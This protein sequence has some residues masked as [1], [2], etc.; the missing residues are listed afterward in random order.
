MVWIVR[1]LW[2]IPVLPAFAAAL[3]SLA[4]Q[5]RRKFAAYLAIGSMSC[6]LL[7]SLL[8]FAH[9]LHHPS[10]EFVNFPWLQFGAT[11]LAFGWLLN[12]LTAVMLVMVSFVGLLIFVYSVGYMAHDEN[13]TRFFCFLSLFAGAMLGIVIS[14]NLLLLFMNWEI[15]G[16]T[17]YLLIGFWYQRPA[18]AAAAKK[19]FIVTRIGDL[20]LF[21]GMMWLYSASG[22]LLFY[23]NGAGCLEHSAIAAMASHGVALGL[24]ASSAIALL[25]FCGAAGK[26]GQ[27]PLHV[28]LPDAMEG[29]TPVSALIHAAT[30]VAAGVFLVARVYPLV[31]A[32]TGT[33]PSA[34]LEVI[35]W[36]GAITALFAACIAVAQNDIKRILA[37]STVSQLGYMMLGLAVG[38]VAVGMFHLI[39]HAFFKALLFL[40]AGSV[41][42]GCEGEQN[43]RRMGG[44]RKLMPVTFI[45]YAIGMLALCGFPLFS[46]FWSKDEILFSAHQW[47][48]SA[49]PYYLGTAGALLTA[50]YMTR[51]I[52]Y[53]FFGTPREKAQPVG[54]PEHAVSLESRESPA[55]MTWPLMILAFFAA[56]LGFIGTPAWPWFQE[57][58]NG[59]PAAFDFRLF[60]ANG[61]LPLMAVSSIIVFVGLALGWWLY[62]RQPVSAAEQPDPL[63]RWQPGI[64]HAL[65]HRLYV[66]Q[67]YDVSVVRIARW[68]SIVSE[69]ID[70]HILGGSIRLVAW[71]VSGISHVDF[72]I[73][74]SFINTGF[75]EGCGEIVRGGRLL[76]RLQNGR[77][78]NYLS[79]LGI[80]LVVFVFYLL[81]GS[82]G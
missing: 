17:S 26:S 29:P 56:L 45:T 3:I 82:R 66:D 30:M 31:A 75:D 23:D 61:L 62:G 13:F 52:C 27:V 22:T 50:F 44:L 70:R 40:G 39:T 80:A 2:L 54:L 15:V 37:Y 49:I 28:W 11:W 72:L 48:L 34:A 55:V 42:H 68:L 77:V 41:I 63:E 19:A 5:S 78:Q 57:F 58:L 74:S 64:F 25:I 1:N 18:A 73:D 59:R 38:G 81:L 76:S 32:S 71:F 65:M 6:S 21:L 20:G 36:V 51:Q 10:V 69:W 14:N 47:N 46:G 4:S 67:I 8:A 60:Q 9:T 24:T 12:P 33:G 35:A 79:V 43:I 53:V 16:L 7:L